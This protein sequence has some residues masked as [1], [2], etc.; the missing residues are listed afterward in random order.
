MLIHS[1]IFKSSLETLYLRLKRNRLYKWINRKLMLNIIIT[2]LTAVAQASK[3][4]KA[5]AIIKIF[6]MFY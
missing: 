6:L 4:I 3:K 1:K 2:I 5:V